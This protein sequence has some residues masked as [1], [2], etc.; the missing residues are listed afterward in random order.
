MPFQPRS[1]DEI[2][3]QVL[4]NIGSG[5]DRITNFVSGSFNDRLAAS[6]SEQVREAELKALAAELAGYVDYAGKTLTEEDLETLGIEGVDPDEINQYMDDQQLDNLAA[7]MSV[8]RDPGA[9]ATGQVVIQTSDDSVQIPEGYEFGTQADNDDE[10]LIFQVDADGDGEITEDSDAYVQPASGETQVTAD[11]IAADYGTE[12]NIGSEVITY[13]PTPKPGIQGVSNSDPTSGGE[14]EQT[15]ESLREDIRVALVS[16]AQGGTS[17]GIKRYIT[18][19]NDNVNNVGIDEFL[20]QSP[21]FV[22]VVVDGGSASDVKQLIE[23]S[24][25]VGVKHNL[26]RPTDINVGS[27]AQVVGEGVDTS[28]VEGVI[29]QYL[30]QLGVSERFYRSELM[31]SIYTSDADISSVG[32]LSMYI[33]QVVEEQFTYDSNTAIYPVR[34]GRF[35]YVDEEEHR[36]VSMS[37]TSQFYTTFPNF[38]SS[39]MTVV[40]TVDE[41]DVELVQ[42]S[43]SDYTILTDSDSNNV[44]IELTGNTV[45]DQRTTI[46]ITYKHSNW[47]VDNVVGEDGTE[48][49]Q[50]TDWDVTDNDS[51]DHMDAIE[52]L[53]G[54]TPA[55]GERFHVTYTPK[56]TFRGD[57]G[58]NDRELFVPDDLNITAEQLQE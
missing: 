50:G 5:I 3:E 10:H 57:L 40:A 24:R 17:D 7:N 1:P 2:Y 20:D 54:S 51:D 4:S 36:F 19:N 42:G 26:V 55:D 22:D 39:S 11:V 21:P 30:S 58:S 14:D 44:G 38:T 29:S 33:T 18:E 45:P 23:E 31:S 28:D 56:R 37:D 27:F 25:P 16:S 47:S 48:Y 8:E 49:V 53:S 35:G 34:F 9:R 13:I 15:N 6:Y 41:D 32:S 12:Y 43:S 46:Q 52:W